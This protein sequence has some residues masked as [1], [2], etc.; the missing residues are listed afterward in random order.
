MAATLIRLKLRLMANDFG[1]SLWTIFGTA[2]V[3]IY[4]LGMATIFLVIQIR[5][6]DGNESFQNVLSMSVL[7]G[8][9]AFLFWI[10][11]PVFVAGGDALMD[12]RRFVTFAVPRRSLILGLILSAMISVGSVITVVWLIG[13][14][15]LWRWDLGALAVALLSLPLLLITYSMVAQAITTAMSAWFGGRRSRDVL[16]LLGMA[17]AVGAAPIVITVM[18]A[19][20]TFGEALPVIVEVLSFTPLAAG[21]ALPA[22]VAEGDLLGA[23][24]RLGVVLGTVLL[25]LL[26]IRAALVSITERPAA[27]S[28]RRTA[29]RGAIGF[30]SLVPAQPWG[31]VAARCLT[32][33]LKDP[34]YGGSLI[35]VPVL[36][37]VAVFMSAQVGTVWMLLALGPF[38]AWVLGFG[39]AADIS[40]DSTAFAQHVTAGVRGTDDRLGRAAALLVF[41]LPLTLLAAGIPAALEGGAGTVVVS[42]GL[43]LG[44]LLVGVGVSS[45]TSA[46]LLYPVPQPGDSP[47]ATPQGSAGRSLV[48]QSA[49]WLIMIG[50][51]IPEL[52]LWI[53][54][55]ITSET[56]AAATL[57]L[58]ALGKGLLVLGWGI[59]MGA[60]VYD[61]RL[62]EIYQQV[63]SYA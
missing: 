55:L 27:A 13:Q 51:M 42:V 15:M 31:A 18:N 29:R 44:M 32:Y 39:I 26:V 5:M 28:R 43:S 63:R 56:W 10:L 62:P 60:R 33:W 17:A 36:A 48:M 24:A 1:R 23:A 50:L 12:P 34:R 49:S 57:L 8:A 2:L 19:F 46:R 6:G 61:R 35:I 40:Y 7:L 45:V 11:I 16:A 54:W 30:F 53:V 52:V 47:F 21:P 41:A 37:V 59:R 25:A 4:G 38:V 20:E 14:V 3:L 9:A 22:A 58:I